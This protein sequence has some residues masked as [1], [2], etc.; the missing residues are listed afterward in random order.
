MIIGYARVS[1]DE[2]NPDLQR[3][4]LEEAGAARVFTDYE[5]GWK[6]DRPE[7]SRALDV[8]RSG[9]T[10]MIWR[11]DRLGRSTAQLIRLA[12]ELRQRDVALRSLQEQLDTRTPAGQFFFTLTAAFA[13]MESRLNSERTRAGI[14]AARRRGRRVGGKSVFHDPKNVA[15]AQ[16]L[17]R[18][19][20][21]TKRE[22]ARRLGVGTNTL[23]QWFPGGSPDSFTGQR[24]NGDG[25][26]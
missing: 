26:L 7:L 20:G 10:L 12:E 8:A 24:K 13:E 3:H 21:L 19:G 4:A 6:A 25:Q 11:F 17:L 16:S 1:T 5:R 15:F 14:A 23:Y 2:Q 22:I 9:D 18:D